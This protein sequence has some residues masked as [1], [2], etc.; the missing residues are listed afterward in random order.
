ME[1]IRL[2]AMDMDGT[3]LG[4]AL[5]GIPAENAEAL[6]E[7][8]RR[9]IALA[10]VSGRPPD[11]AGFFAL[12]AGLDM[13]VLSLNGCAVQRTPLGE[14]TACRFIPE[15][16]ARRVC[17]LIGE[18]GLA[19]SL[20]S[21]HD[22]ALSEPPQ[23]M[24]AAMRNVGTFLDRPGGRTRFW[25]DGDHTGPL[26]PRVSKL[27]VISEDRPEALARLG[28]RIAA[29]VPEVA[30]TS[31]WANNI[32]IIPTGADKGTALT[33]LAG[34][35]GIPLAQVMAIGDN[36]NDVPMLDVAGCAVAVGN[37]TPAAK[38]TA[39]W[40]APANVENGV[41]AAIRALALGDG[42]CLRLMRQGGSAEG[43]IRKNLGFYSAASCVIIKGKQ[44]AEGRRRPGGDETTSADD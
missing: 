33:A 22:V 19:C 29:Q 41:A 12:D 3:L 10:L 26:M 38:Q 18:A 28:E 31:S 5:D 8:S 32:E 1:R 40:I 7:A 14:V 15:Q 17:A 6:R 30:V 16:A 27:V 11:D 21:V 39:R 24:P 23:D 36:G 25:P 4:R 2:I 37:A 13:H 34:S 44:N 42:A 35:L 9:G 20:F 43:R